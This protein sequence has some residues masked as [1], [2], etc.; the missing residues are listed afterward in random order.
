M[1]KA[2]KVFKHPSLGKVRGVDEDGQM[3]LLWKDI[4]DILRLQQPHK[5]LVCV[6]HRDKTKK[7]FKGKIVNM[8]TV[9]GLTGLLNRSHREEAPVFLEWIDQGAFSVKHT[10]RLEVP[11]FFEQINQAISSAEKVENPLRK[12]TVGL[13]IFKHNEFGQVRVVMRDEKPWFVAKDV[14]EILG[15]QNTNKAI[16]DHCKHAKSLKG[17]ETLPLVKCPELQE[18][19]P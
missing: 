6:F 13:E 16:L 19:H 15:Y 1:M 8:V 3:W 4:A 17:N 7:K 12:E 9:A 10:E 11:A 14:A 2:S 18:M 5:Y